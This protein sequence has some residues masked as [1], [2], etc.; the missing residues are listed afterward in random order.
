MRIEHVKAFKKRTGKLVKKD[1]IDNLYSSGDDK[2][3]RNFIIK[4]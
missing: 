2:N 4:A 1:C 3:C